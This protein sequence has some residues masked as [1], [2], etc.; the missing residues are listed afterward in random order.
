VTCIYLVSNDPETIAKNKKPRTSSH[1]QINYRKNEIIYC[2]TDEAKMIS[3]ETI[4]INQTVF[5]RSYGYDSIRI[6]DRGLSPIIFTLTS[7]FMKI[8]LNLLNS[9]IS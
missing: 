4:E 9:I 3:I 6:T 2:K 7:S 5:R 1:K 8:I